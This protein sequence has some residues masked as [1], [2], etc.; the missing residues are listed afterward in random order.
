MITLGIFTSTRAEYGM[1]SALLNK[2]GSDKEINY[3]L[4]VGGT[5]L[6]REYGLTI[7][8]IKKNNHKISDIFDYLLNNDDPYN[9]VRS[10]GI[11]NFELSTIF[12]N[13]N[14]DYT[15]ILGDRYE[16]IPIVLSSILYKKPIIHLHGGEATEGLI[17]EQI[18]HM[19]TKAAHLH[20]VSCDEYKNNIRKMGESESRIFNVGALSVDNIINNETI[21]KNQLFNE[22]QLDQ[23]KKTILLTYHPVTLEYKLEPLI[24]IK[25]IFKALNKFNF[26]TVITAPNIEIERNVII[27]YI[28]KIVN[29][30]KNY[31]F[32][33]SLGMNKYFNLIPHCEFV[34]G[35]S[36]SGIN[37]VPF[38][39]I[40]TIN[41][42]DRQ[43]GR[44][45][46]ESVIDVG[47]TINSIV[48]GI[49][50]ALDP[51]FRS[52]I[53]EMKYKFGDGHASEK[54]LK[55]LRN[56]E[57]NENFMRKKLDF[58]SYG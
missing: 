41:I 23:S 3:K 56:I 28:E 19:I 24:Q 26:Q 37:E 38:F 57:I 12:N 29:S 5:H 40:P 22:L 53:K 20:F 1:L 49:K 32:I 44:I 21:D 52:R 31:R 4:F 27:Y 48:E 15:C 58:P 33:E 35:N 47:Y 36:S 14:F 54:I 17:D 8:E 25:N 50:K 11:E 34:I 30:N 55:T 7:N 39:K 43:K 6:A 2:I 13:Y 18:R 10:M 45:R 46:H 51:N 42:G 16:L 9:L